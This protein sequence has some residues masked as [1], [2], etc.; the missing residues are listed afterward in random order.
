MG[1]LGAVETEFWNRYLAVAGDP[2]LARA[3]VSASMP[4]DERNAD[5]LLSLY[6]AGKKSA[7]SGLVRDYEQAGD[8]LPRAGTYWILL[9]SK[10][11]PRCIAKTVRV[12]LH[13]F[14]DVPEYVARAEGEG[15]LSLAYWRKAHAEFFGT[16]LA[17]LGI[18]DLE[19]EMVVTEFFELVLS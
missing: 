15:D 6:L 3:Q 13:R 17:K 5:E 7:G 1:K 12:E 2:A 11:V 4:G 8:P 14:R 16:Y 10:G 9:D 19:N 18:T